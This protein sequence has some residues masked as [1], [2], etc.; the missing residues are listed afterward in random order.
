MTDEIFMVP[1]TIDGFKKWWGFDSEPAL[2]KF[3]GP[4]VGSGE[5]GIFDVWRRKKPEFWNTKKSYSPFK[6]LETEIIRTNKQ[7]SILIPVYNRFNFTDFNELKIEYTFRGE[8]ETFKEC[9]SPAAYKRKS[10][11]AC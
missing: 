7:D 2:Q 8:K 5:W 4:T 10:F 3:Q 9:K 1:D 6:V 11:P